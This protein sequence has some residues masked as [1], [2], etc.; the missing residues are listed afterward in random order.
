MPS[1]DSALF[2]NVISNSEQ[3]EDGLWYTTFSGTLPDT[4][5]AKYVLLMV[6]ETSNIRISTKDHNNA[7][8]AS[9]GSNFIVTYGRLNII[10]N[11]IS[12][13]A[14]GQRSAKIIVF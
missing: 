2:Y 1:L 10:D 6:G 4:F 14:K 13:S 5:N 3:D 12:G 7:W 8:T 9:S 11:V